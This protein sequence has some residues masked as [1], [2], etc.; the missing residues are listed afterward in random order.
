MCRPRERALGADSG[1]LPL[2]RTEYSGVA[3]AGAHAT[4][5]IRGRLPGLSLHAQARGLRHR[6]RVPAVG[7][8]GLATRVASAVQYRPKTEK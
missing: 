8:A 3:A 2:C 1:R 5:R 6:H 7:V 4:L